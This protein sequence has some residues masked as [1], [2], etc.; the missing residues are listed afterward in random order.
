MYNWI[1]DF[2]MICSSSIEVGMFGSM[3]FIGSTIC[4]IGLLFISQVDWWVIIIVSQVLILG[5]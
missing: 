5:I 1:Y 3:W 4:G 2:D